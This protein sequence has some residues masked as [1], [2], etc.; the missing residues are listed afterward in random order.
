MKVR[1]KGKSL[2]VVVVGSPNVNPGYRLVDNKEYPQIT[3]DY[4]KS[5]QTWKTLPCDIFLGAHGN[6]YGLEK[7]YPLLAAGKEN[8]FVD[9]AGYKAWIED[10]E[11]AFRKTLAE[12]QAA[13]AASQSAAK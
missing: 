10:R 8:P 5:F 6:Y 7:K 1:D 12:Q 2:D 4:E 9:P 3:A 13:P 11:R